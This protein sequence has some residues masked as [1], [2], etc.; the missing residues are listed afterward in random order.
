MGWWVANPKLLSFVFVLW[1]SQ[2]WWAIWLITFFTFH[3]NN[4]V[5][6]PPMNTVPSSVF[7]FFVT[8]TPPSGWFVSVNKSTWMTVWWERWQLGKTHSRTRV[9]SNVPYSEQ[10]RPEIVPATTS[11]ELE[12]TPSLIVDE[13]TELHT[14]NNV[15]LSFKKFLVW[16]PDGGEESGN[17]M[18]SDDA[19]RKTG[20]LCYWWPVSPRPHWNLL[21]SALWRNLLLLI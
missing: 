19:N 12:A 3:V 15:L 10:E 6:V 5:L 14:T 16:R 17:N 13:Q 2:Q 1:D 9:H 21:Q 4:L 18:Y 7:V 20:F 11:Q 8:A